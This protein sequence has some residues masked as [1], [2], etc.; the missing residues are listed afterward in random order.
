MDNEPIIIYITGNVILDP[1][2]TACNNGTAFCKYGLNGLAVPEKST[3]HE[4]AS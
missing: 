3:T 2:Q 1:V 4:W